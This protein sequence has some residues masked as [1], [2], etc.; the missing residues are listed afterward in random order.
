MGFWVGVVWRGPGGY[1]A[2]RRCGHAPVDELCFRRS[3]LRRVAIWPFDH[4]LGERLIESR[5]GRATLVLCGLSMSS[6]GGG[7]PKLSAIFLI[8]E[9]TLIRICSGITSGGS[10][11]RLLEHPAEG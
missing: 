2:E 5:R 6:A 1:Y 4:A 10:A 11:K 8:F 7:G 3:Q 9:L